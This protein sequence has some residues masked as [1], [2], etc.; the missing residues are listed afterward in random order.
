V[1]L[2]APVALLAAGAAGFASLAVLQAEGGGAAALDARV[3]GWIAAEMPGWAEAAALPFTWLGS[4]AALAALCAA[5]AAVA[6]GGRR[7]LAAALLGAVLLADQL[8]VHALKGAFAR[9]RPDAGSAIPLPGSPS[10]PSGHAANATAAF[11]ALA[12]VVCLRR[13]SPRARGAALGA[14][15]ALALAVGASRVVLN[16]HYVTDVL[17]GFCLGLA[18]LAAAL[19][20]RPA[21]WLRLASRG[22]RPLGYHRRDGRDA[23]A[24]GAAPGDQGPARLGP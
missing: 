15:A 8:L 13:S 17:A 2:R 4:L 21:A 20:V 6:P 18:V 16:V 10:F 9:P 7:R 11:G 14:A 3:A 24:R 22:S 1:S 12:V 23:D 5:A 19:A